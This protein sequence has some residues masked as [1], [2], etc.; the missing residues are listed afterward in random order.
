[1]YFDDIIC[2][3]IKIISD[4]VDWALTEKKEKQFREEFEKRNEKRN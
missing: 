4:L 2:V 1:M 3:V